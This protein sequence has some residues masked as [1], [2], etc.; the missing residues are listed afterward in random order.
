MGWMRLRVMEEM[1]DWKIIDL[2]VISVNM[3]I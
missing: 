1:F 3:L 2:E